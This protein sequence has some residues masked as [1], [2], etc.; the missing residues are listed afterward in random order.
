MQADCPW[1]AG[2]HRQPLCTAAQRLLSLLLLVCGQVGFADVGSEADCG[3]H[4]DMQRALAGLHSFLYATL[5]CTHLQQTAGLTPRCGASPQ[6]L[7][8]HSGAQVGLLC[9]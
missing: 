1:Q 9:G 8:W 7:I 6:A 2:S 4:V 3:M 5:T